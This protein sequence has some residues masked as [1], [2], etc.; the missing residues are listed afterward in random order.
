MI[1]LTLLTGVSFSQEAV[2]PDFSQIQA[3]FWINRSHAN[4]YDVPV[5]EQ[6][7]APVD[8]REYIRDLLELSRQWFSGIIY[9]YQFIYRPSDQVREVS[10]LFTIE[11]V[12]Q[13]PW[14]DNDLEYLG[15]YEEDQKIE[16]SFRYFPKD[17]E[18]SRLK[19]WRSSR[20]PDMVG[21]AELPDRTDMQSRMESF[22]EAV[23]QAIRNYYRQV[24]PNKPREIR[25]RIALRN[26][27]RSFADGGRIF[28]SLRVIIDTEEV[29][30][31][32]HF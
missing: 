16:L 26:V 30:E 19:A 12:H 5:T 29:Q 13:I 3:V 2:Y 25:G 23:K 4:S 24:I 7:L 31:Y 11:P 9:G 18:R 28:T 22:D 20:L 6:I 8:D 17:Y 10:E 15:Y 32:Q 1:W 27:P 14:G 21:Q